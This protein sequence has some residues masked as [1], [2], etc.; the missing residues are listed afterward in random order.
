MPPRSLLEHSEPRGILP[1][2]QQVSSGCGIAF[3]QIGSL[4]IQRMGG[5]QAA[6]TQKHRLLLIGAALLA[7]TPEQGYSVGEAPLEKGDPAADQ[8]KHPARRGQGGSRPRRRAARQAAAVHLRG[9]PSVLQG[10]ALG[11]AARLK[12]ERARSRGRTPARARGSG[13]QERAEP[14]PPAGS[15]RRSRAGKRQWRARP[16]AT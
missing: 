6:G 15:A 11:S 7:E 14:P 13:R 8:R 10:K 9:V 16:A 3:S 12:P 2:F 4:S 1:A 5:E